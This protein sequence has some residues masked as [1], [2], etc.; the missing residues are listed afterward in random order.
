MDQ[1]GCQLDVIAH[2]LLVLC[3]AV[4][5]SDTTGQVSVHTG[6]QFTLPESDVLQVP[7]YLLNVNTAVKSHP[8]TAEK[9][10]E[11][12]LSALSQ[13]RASVATHHLASLD[14]AKVRSFLPPL[15]L[16]L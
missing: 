2:Y 3:N 9:P 12:S 1:L 11:G 15:W 5:V 13:N 16:G 6:T 10:M 8:A 7:T 4:Y 14:H